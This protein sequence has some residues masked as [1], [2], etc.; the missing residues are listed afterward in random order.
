MRPGDWLNGVPV[1][2]LGLREKEFTVALQY[3][4]GVQ[5]CQAAGPYNACDQDSDEFGDH[6]IGCST[7]GVRIFRH[8]GIRDTLHKIAK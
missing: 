3:R 8:N 1:Q 4:L 5:V 2:A 7:N 6:A